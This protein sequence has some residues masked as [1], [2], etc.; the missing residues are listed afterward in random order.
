MDASN[1]P[2]DRRTLRRMQ[3]YRLAGMR[4][5]TGSSGIPL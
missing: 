2:D 3:V 1:L 5:K 4:E